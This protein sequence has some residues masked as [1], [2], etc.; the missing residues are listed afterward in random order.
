MKNI[1]FD[2]IIRLIQDGRRA[3]EII[4][5]LGLDC[6]FVDFSNLVRRSGRK[7]SEMR[8]PG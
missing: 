3:Q 4:S 5:T 2:P 6:S 8:S 7:Y 1:D